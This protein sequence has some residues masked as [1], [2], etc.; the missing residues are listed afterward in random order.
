M[1]RALAGSGGG[2]IAPIIPIYIR[3]PAH[4]ICSG[5]PA[6]CLCIR[7]S[8]R[9]SYL[10]IEILHPLLQAVLISLHGNTASATPCGSH[11]SSWKYCIRSSRRFSYIF[12]EILHPLLQ[13]VLPSLGLF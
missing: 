1:L 7:S 5:F 12:I 3:T 6:V 10:S 11:I 13:A 2:G 4:T 8:R 9:F